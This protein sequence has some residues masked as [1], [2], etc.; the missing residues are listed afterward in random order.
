MAE[1]LD[2]Q[3]DWREVAPPHSIEDERADHYP[4]IQRCAREISRGTARE[5]RAAAWSL[6]RSRDERAVSPLLRGISDPEGD[7]RLAAAQSLAGFA[8]LPRW[9]AEPLL[10]AL[11]D[12]DPGVRLAAAEA[13][14]VVP[15]AAAGAGLVMALADTSA[16]VRARAAESI[17]C[18]GQGGV[19]LDDAIVPLIGLLGDE[20]A[21]V[22]YQ[23][24]WALAYQGGSL[25]EE[26]RAAWRSS[27]RGQVVWASVARI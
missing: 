8:T 25:F 19:L 12:P 23:A 10:W 18:L 3:V 11:R 1:M 24:Y 15:G 27:D 5:R 4:A 17:A 9:A 20:D 2:W 13:L 26:V 21:H 6:G 16:A 14:R 7:V 22:A